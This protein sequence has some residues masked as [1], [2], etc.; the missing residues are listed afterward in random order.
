MY[1]PEV[2]GLCPEAPVGQIE[3][4][5]TPCDGDES[6]CT[7][8]RIQLFQC[9]Q[10]HQDD[11]QVRDQRCCR[12]LYSFL[13]VVPQGLRDQQHQQG[14]GA[15]PEDKPNTHP[16]IRAEITSRLPCLLA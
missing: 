1:V 4:V 11:R 13:G 14:P 6:Q 12:Y 5:N 9:K 8:V 15:N 10:G 7:L 16:V 3:H 2:D